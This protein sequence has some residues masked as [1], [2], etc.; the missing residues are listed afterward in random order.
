[1]KSWNVDT[2][3]CAEVY[4]AVLPNSAILSRHDE[5]TIL[6]NEFFNLLSYA[7][8]A[9]MFDDPPLVP[10]PIGCHKDDILTQSQM[11]KTQDCAEFIA[12]QKSKIAGLQKFD[13]MNTHPISHLLQR[14][15]LI[16]SIWSYHRKWLPNGPY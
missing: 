8:I 11:L 13:V 4:S 16:S 15:K 7:H 2:S 1:L 14:A 5:K 3:V 12:C 9:M 6:D 10:Q